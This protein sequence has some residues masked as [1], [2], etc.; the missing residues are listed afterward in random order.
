MYLEIKRIFSGFTSQ[1]A[2]S[3]LCRWARARS[4]CLTIFCASA[5]EYGLAGACHAVGTTRLC[6]SPPLRKSAYAWFQCR[7]SL[8]WV[9]FQKGHLHFLAFY[10][11]FHLDNPCW[12]S[13]KFYHTTSFVIL[14]AVNASMGT[15]VWSYSTLKLYTV[16]WPCL[17]LL[18][19]P[20]YARKKKP[21]AMLHQSL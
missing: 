2:I 17:I 14:S 20:S 9:L 1:W 15:I 11:V 13:N 16:D 10:D 8:S 6:S 7:Q 3:C 4:S 21:F 18:L 5:S 12:C 19:Q